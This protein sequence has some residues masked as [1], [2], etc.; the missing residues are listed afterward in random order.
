MLVPL[1]FPISIEGRSS[2]LLKIC[3]I[4]PLQILVSGSR[5]LT[6]KVVIKETDTL[7]IDLSSLKK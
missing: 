4:L 5:K 2:D 7:E 3:I 1:T 6:F